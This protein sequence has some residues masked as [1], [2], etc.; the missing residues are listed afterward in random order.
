MLRCATEADFDRL[1]E[2]GAAMHAE[3]PSYR[4]MPFDGVVLRNTLGF[5]RENGFICV[6]DVDGRINGVMVAVISPSWFGSGKTASDL[7]LFI[8]PAARGGSLAYRLIERFI[9]WS[10]ANNVNAQYLGITTNVHPERTGALFE[11]LGFEPVG[12]LYMRKGSHV[13]RS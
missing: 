6:N 11:R 12:G 1:I 8:E 10:D 5:V 9:H 3:S 2:L 13:H 7:A 4:H